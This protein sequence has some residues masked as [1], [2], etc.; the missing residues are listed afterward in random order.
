M[1]VESFKPTLWEGALIANF[2]SLSIADVLATPPSDI[3]GKGIG[4]SR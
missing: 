2:H 1:S 4:S 3:K